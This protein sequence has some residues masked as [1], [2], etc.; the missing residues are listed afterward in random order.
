MASGPVLYEG[1]NLFIDRAKIQVRAGDG[2]N[3]CVSF[4]RETFVPTGGPD[5][6][7]GGK[8]GSVYVQGDSQLHTLEDLQY[9]KKYVAERGQHGMGAR[10]F[11]P[12][13][14]DLI[15]RVPLGTRIYVDGLLA[16]DIVMQGQKVCVAKGGR[17]GKGNALFA[18]PTNRTPQKATP[19]QKGEE[20]HL[21]LELKLMA[22]VGMVGMPNAGKSTLL[23]MLTAASPKIGAYPFTT[24]HPNLGIV[25]PAEYSSFVLADIPGLIEGASEGRGLG[26]DFLR[27]I[28]RTRVLLYLIDAASDN[29]KEDLKM[30]KR[31]LKQWNPDLLKR[32]SLIVLSRTDLLNGSELPKGPWKMGISSATQEG[33]ETLIA[34]V[35]KLLQSAPVPEFYREPEVDDDIM[36][37][38]DEDDA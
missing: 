19:G 12:S 15:I 1:N 20:K 7:N 24:L 34:K 28:E 31:E 37:I 29:P 16:A 36:E 35:W 9:K 13:A 22:D 27:H 3:G 17:G 23:S 18:T 5:G 33:L 4:R 38:E 26:Y 11:G 30:L 14:D 32:P 6:G 21:L 25:K 2:G 8:G 10:K